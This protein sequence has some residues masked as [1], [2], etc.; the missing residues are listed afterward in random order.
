MSKKKS[1][2]KD[3]PVLTDIILFDDKA[4][5]DGKNSPSAEIFHHTPSE[6]PEHTVQPAQVAEKVAQP[7]SEP[8]APK[9]AK[10]SKLHK[11]QKAISRNEKQLEAL[12]DEITEDVK[13]ESSQQIEQAVRKSIDK[14]VR[15]ALEKSTAIMR[16]AMLVQL[17]DNLSPIIELILEEIEDDQKKA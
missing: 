3:I 7:V 14:A 10:P 4:G 5:D 9:T 11:A 8:P 17:S 13:N 6:Q 16:E 1:T 15:D 2:P 12:I